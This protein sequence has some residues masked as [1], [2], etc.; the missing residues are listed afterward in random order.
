MLETERAIGR[1]IGWGAWESIEAARSPGASSLTP[2][3]SHCQWYLHKSGK[4]L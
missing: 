1:L 2:A 4:W 3:F